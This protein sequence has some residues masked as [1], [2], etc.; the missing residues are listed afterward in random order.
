MHRDRLFVM[1]A[2]YGLYTINLA[3]KEVKMLLHANDVKPSMKFPNDLDITADGKVIYF[4]DSSC[5]F[6]ITK[7]IYEA[8]EGEFGELQ[9]K[10]NL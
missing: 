9:S 5:R 8:L 4:T 7:L 10:L 2:I 3:T 1:D 6:P